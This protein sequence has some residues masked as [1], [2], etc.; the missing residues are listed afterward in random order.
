MPRTRP[1]LTRRSVL[2]GAA[3]AT[4]ALATG[5]GTANA[6]SATATSSWPT[7]IPLPNGFLCEGIA[8]GRKPYAYFGSRADGAVYRADLR[9]G[10]G[11]IVYAGATGTITNGLKVDDQDGLLY[12]SSGSTEGA[13]RIVDSRTGR[14]VATYQLTDPTGHFI[15]DVTLLG[16]RAWFTDSYGA[17]LY[18]VPR[19]GKGDV[20]ELPIGGDWVQP[21]TGIGANG[22]VDTPD[23]KALIVVNGGNLYRVPLRTGEA[24]RI[25]LSGTTALTYGDGLV[26]VG[27]TLYVVQNR[28]NQVSVLDLDPK[29]TTA[30]LTRTI[31]DPLADIPTTAARFGDR[32]YLVNARFTSP[33]VPET[34]FNAFSVAL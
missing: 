18:G 31:T 8:I 16:D 15:N 22:L 7:E 21:T 11:T 4:L 23:G 14:V 19:D 32:L 6:S 29:I 2:G 25:T 30:T 13:A 24:A 5:A 10:E 27:H 33:Q 12:L 28:L 26:R 20:R 9:T 34:T 1:T 17:V 3:L